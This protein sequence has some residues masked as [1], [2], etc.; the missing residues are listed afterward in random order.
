MD[1]RRKVDQLLDE[2]IELNKQLNKED[3]NHENYL[4][5]EAKLAE[6]T[7][8]IKILTSEGR[9]KGLWTDSPE[10]LAQPMR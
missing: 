4:K 1:L 9:D 6:I 8:T 7:N 10:F 2:T 3:N 5:L